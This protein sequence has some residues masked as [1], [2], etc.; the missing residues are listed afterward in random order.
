MTRRRAG[1]APEATPSRQERA[2]ATPQPKTPSAA[3]CELAQLKAIIEALIFASPEP[4]T[5]KALYKLL[6]DEPKEDVQA[7]LDALKEDYE[8][9]RRPAARR[10]RRR[11]S[12]HDAP[13]AARVGAAAVP[14]AHARRS[15]RCRR[16]RRWRSSPTGSRSR[17]PR[18]AR[19]AAST[20]PA[21]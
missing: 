13:R 1:R 2:D 20:P 18:S 11:L 6:D 9:P 19:S 4:L 16:S 15:C 12:D 3:R 21:C 14:R 8:R 10:G 5:P 7:A 17:R